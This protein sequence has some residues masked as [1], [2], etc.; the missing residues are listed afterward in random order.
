MSLQFILKG[1]VINTPALVQIMACR[2]GNDLAPSRRQAITSA[3][4]G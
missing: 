4:D 3:I 1:A 2:L